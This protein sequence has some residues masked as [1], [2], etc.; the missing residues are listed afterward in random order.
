MC[1]GRNNRG[2]L[3]NGSSNTATP[4]N[5][6]GLQS[7]KSISA[8]YSHTCA[9]LDNGSAMCWGRNNYGQL[10]NGNTTDNATPGTV[11]GLQS[12]KYISV[13]GYNHGSHTCALRDSRSAMCWG[14]N[15][16]GQLGNGNTT[17]NVTPGNVINLGNV[18]LP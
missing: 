12:V 16:N 13:G 4:S 17:D 10:G 3:G 6:T 15:A 18:R 7:I 1:W 11:T 5:V 14:K 8:G 9:V 2:Q